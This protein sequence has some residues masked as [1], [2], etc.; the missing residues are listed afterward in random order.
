MPNSV[1]DS[2]GIEVFIAEAIIEIIKSNIIAIFL[3]KPIFDI[4]TTNKTVDWLL[5]FCKNQIIYNL[6]KFYYKL[7]CFV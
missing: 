6:L 3:I 4:L 1:F 5:R 2:S 7:I